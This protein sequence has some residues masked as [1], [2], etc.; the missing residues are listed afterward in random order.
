MLGCSVFE[1]AVFWLGLLHG[2]QRPPGL[3]LFLFW[4]GWEF[5]QLVKGADRV[6]AEHMLACRA[7]ELGNF[8]LC[9]VTSKV[10]EES[11]LKVPVAMLR[12]TVCNKNAEGSQDHTVFIIFS[13]GDYEQFSMLTFLYVY[14][15]PYRTAKLKNT[16]FFLFS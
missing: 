2:D 9:Y 6:S 3:A 10:K 13:L 1:S 16:I 11:K 5:L 4:V 12:C 14:Q 7:Q 15:I 8:L